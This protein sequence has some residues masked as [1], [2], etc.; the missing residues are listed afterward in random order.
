MNIKQELLQKREYQFK[1]AEEASKRNTLVVLPTGMGKTIIALFVTKNRMDKYPNSKLLFLA[2][3]RPLCNQHKNTF[4]KLSDIEGVVVT[5]KIKPEKR[6]QLYKN[7]NFIFATPQTIKNDILQK[8]VALKN[9]SLVVFDEA[10]RAVGNYPYPFIAKKYIADSPFP[11]ILALTASPGATE[12]KIEKIMNNLFIKHVE[13][14][15]HFDADVKKYLP[16][17]QKEFVYVEFPAQIKETI[18]LLNS[19]IKERI[20]WLKQNNL[21]SKKP[22]KS[23]I[24]ALQKT[25]AKQYNSKNNFLALAM[26]KLAEIIKVMHAAELFE[27]QSISAVRDYFQKLK[28][29]KKQTDRRIV[30]DKRILLAMEKIEK[31]W[32]EGYEHPKLE[33]L[34]SIAKLIQKQNKK[35]I[36][37]ANYR[38]TCE[39][40]S[41]CLKLNGIS[42]QIF[43]G[44]LRKGKSGLTQ[45]QQIEIIRKF[46]NGE[47][48]FLISTSIGEEGLDI[49]EVDYVIFYE[50]VPSEIRS[51]QRK[52]RVG[53]TKPGMVIFL[54][55]KKTRDESYYW[56]AFHK[57]KRMRKILKKLKEK[58]KEKSLL[59]WLR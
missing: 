21:L 59:E 49:P 3:T 57:E 32:K 11:L 29:S 1:I 15:T 50:P 44:Q 22:T 52:G 31:L 41:N 35:A 23:E 42:S 19:F 13:I 9:F 34:I 6:E 2:P 27:S 55:T 43:V 8:R 56:A 47:F 36:I 26:I 37:F 25:L 16:P 17:L 45:K 24:I 40:I 53:R 14:R 5:G 12:Q 18:E 46:E 30:N 33:K 38:K 48:N 58:K 4:E 54:I 28:M 7:F 20:E 39:L 10:H 51:I